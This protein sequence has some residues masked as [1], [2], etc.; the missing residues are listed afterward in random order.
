MTKHTLKNRKAVI[1]VACI[2]VVIIAVALGLFI[3]QP[4]V[5]EDSFTFEYGKKVEIDTSAIFGDSSDKVKDIEV[6]YSS[7]K[8]VKDKDYPEV[9]EYELP[10]TYKTMTNHSDK[11]KVTVKDTTKPKF[12]S[13]SEKIEVTK[14][15][16]D[17]DFK[18]HFKA[19]DLSSC[20]LD[21]NTK[22]VNFDKEGD[23]TAKVTATDAH[24]NKESKKFTVVVK[25]EEKTAIAS[26]DNEQKVSPYYKNGILI[27]NKKH[28]VPP[29]FGGGVN[30]TALAAV[31]R[32]IS[33]MKAERLPVDRTTSNYRSYSYQSTLYQNYVSAYGK[34]S[35]DTFS[36]R[37]GYSEHQTG[38]AFDLR[39][40]GGGSLLTN[41]K[42]TSWVAKNAHKYGLIVRYQSG[43][44]WITGYQA[45]PWH[46]RYVGD[47][48]T[49][50]YNSG[51]SLEE[52][53]GV[54]GGG[55]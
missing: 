35:A 34:A 19:S 43:K 49:S 51:L 37:P 48:A 28:P 23:Y 11:L 27:V 24:K 36:A 53:L 52:Y 29:G 47:I 20:T 16:K 25:A 12:T 32:M 7:L 30:Q 40:P 55:Y 22:D 2:A 54:S 8:M 13:F 10:F 5:K 4:K 1:I 33:D 39:E 42:A 3:S 41:S 17:F 46:V 6:D 26:A 18:K 38:L 44:E 14:G 50:I 21:I 45:E 9:G 31:N 15:N